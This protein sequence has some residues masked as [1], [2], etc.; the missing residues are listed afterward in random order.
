MQGTTGLAIIDE[1]QT[2][3]AGQGHGRDGLVA[4]AEVHQ[5][6]RGRHVPVPQVLVRDLMMPLQ[7]AGL[8]VESDDAVGVEF[9]PLGA[10]VQVADG[11]ED[12]AVF[13]VDGDGRPDVGAAAVLPLF[14]DIA[15]MIGLARLGHGVE[16]PDQFAGADIPGAHVAAR[17]GRSHLAGTSAGDHQVLVD[18]DRVGNGEGVTAAFAHDL[19]RHAH[20]GV[21]LAVLAEVRR[22]LT[23]AH[24]QRRQI[25]LVGGED[26]ARAMGLVARP[27]GDAATVD[28]A[29]RF[30]FPQHLARF[31]RQGGDGGLEVGQV[32]I[33]RGRD[34]HHA[35]D[36]QGR[37]LP[38]VIQAAVALL[39]R[40]AAVTEGPGA[41]QLAHVVGRDLRQGREVGRAGVL[42]IAAPGFAVVR[43]GARILS[44]SRGSGHE[45]QRQAG[46]D[47]FQGASVH[48]AFLCD[49]HCWGAS[50]VTSASVRP[51]AHLMPSRWKVR[52]AG[53]SQI[54]ST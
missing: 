14:A 44:E 27:P 42:A 23:R 43:L 37:H 53:S 30:P 41:L 19:G 26:D 39:V 32:R 15:F 38:A 24:V 5:D 28:V 16:G 11:G 6:R 18:G 31:G 7:R 21:D 29:V 52:T 10:A 34:V 12:D 33:G 8:G 17:S 9:R 40:A 51:R 3:L 4:L 46:A 48:G 45:D 2:L 49:Y 20:V 35:I 47:A 36:H 50:G 54:C 13:L 1:Q 25:A 22:Q